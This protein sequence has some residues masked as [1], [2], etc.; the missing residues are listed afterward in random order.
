[1][2]NLQQQGVT[3]DKWRMNVL[4]NCGVK[5]GANMRINVDI[6]KFGW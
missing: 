3:I 6:S 4:G 2:D 5:Q 1:M